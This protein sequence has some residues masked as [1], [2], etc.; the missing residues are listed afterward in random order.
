[1]LHIRRRL[2]SQTSMN[3]V[4]MI[5]VVLQLILYFMV[6]TTLILTP[7]IK[8]ILPSSSTSQLEFMDKLMVTVVSRE[9]IYLNE[10][11]VSLEAL[12]ER[13][14]RFTPQ[15]KEELKGV[16]LEGDQAISYSLVIE[17]LDTLRRNGFK[18]INMRT[19]EASS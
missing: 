9:E 17:V 18:G 19:R 15:Q 12:N 10:E 13:L 2:T 4:P 1:M 14:S 16:V 11:R 3:M 8:L 6:S 7:G 5:D